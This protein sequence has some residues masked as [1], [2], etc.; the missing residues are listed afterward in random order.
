MT[1]A[2]PSEVRLV[3]AR[4][5]D[6]PVDAAPVLTEPAAVADPAGPTA[7]AMSITD[8]PE[9]VAW[10]VS[11]ASVDAGVA[12][13]EIL[14][15]DHGTDVWIVALVGPGGETLSVRRERVWEA[16]QALVRRRTDAVRADAEALT[17][18]STGGDVTVDAARAPM[19]QDLERVRRRRRD[20]P[21]D[22]AAV[23]RLHAAVTAVAGPAPPE[24]PAWLPIVTAGPPPRRRPTRL[25][26]AL[27]RLFGESDVVAQ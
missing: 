20:E 21:V 27:A 23:D 5:M 18:R 22:L 25:V 26:R 16:L 3:A 13:T 24:H 12:H 7:L 2:V 9:L 4:L 11:P 10:L 8:Q 19:V 17:L 6:V 15:D 1:L 14:P